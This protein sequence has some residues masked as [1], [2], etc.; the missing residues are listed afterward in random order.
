MKLPAKF[1]WLML[2]TI[3]VA[4]DCKE[5]PPNRETE[6][7][8]GSWHDQLY[9]EGTQA[10][11]KCRPG[12]RTFGTI[13]M[14]CR[15]GEWVAV[16]PSRICRKRPCGYPGD[17][18]FGSFDLVEGSEF[19]YG[20]TVVYTCEEGYRLV[21][22]IN[23]RKCEADG[24]TN[25][26]PVCEVI[27]CLPVSEPE[28]GRII[29]GGF[30]VNQEYT[31]GQVIRFEC[32][33]GFVLNAAKE[34]HCS[35][36][37]WSAEKPNCVGISCDLPHIP[38]GQPISLKTTFK[39][40]E[41]LQ[42]KCHRGYS[43]SRRADAV[44]T[45]SGWA[46][47]PECKEMT[48][49]PLRIA[50]GDYSPKSTT[51]RLEDEVTYWCKNGFY[52]ASRGTTAKC[53][54]TG[55][56]PPPRCGFK[57]CDFPE[58]KHG[59]LHHE[60]YYRPYF[61]VAI[62][63]YY[64]YS[65]ASGF[66]THSRRSWDYI[67]CGRD[68]WSPAVPCRRQCI[69]NYLENG[70]S[71]SR[72]AKYIQGDS[73]IVR[74][75]AG[76]TLQN[77]Q[78]SLT[79]TENGWSPLPK[80]IRVKT[81]SKS[82]LEIQNGF[83]SESESTYPVGKEARYKCKDGYITED[84]QTTGSIRCLQSGWSARPRC[85]KSCDMPIFE[86]ARATGD[87]TWF[88][89]N[90]NLVYVCHDGYKNG[91]GHTRGSIQCGTDGW[92]D[93]PT[94]REKECGVPNI[95]P[96]VIA[97]PKKDKYKVGDVLKF[98]C[99]RRLK[100]VGTDSVQ[101]YHFGWSPS[102]PTCKGEVR[103]CGPRPSLLN[104]EAK[105]APR[106]EYAHGEVVEYVCSPRFLMKGSNRIQCVDGEWTV[107][108]LCV[109]ENSTCDTVPEV[110]NGYAVSSAPPYRHGESVEFRCTETFAMSGRRSATCVR[111]VW[112]RPP[113]CV[114]ITEP[115]KCKLPKLILNVEPVSDK[116]TYHHN[117]NVSYT[118]KGESKQKNSICINGRWDPK[119]T[120]TEV[121][122]CPPPPQIPRARNMTTT[123]NY[124]DGDK[125]SILCE[126][127]A[128]MQGGEEIVCKNG[129]WQ[130][131]PR[132]VEK[133]PCSQPPHIEHGTVN[134]SRSSEERNGTSEPRPYAHGTK[135]SYLCEDGFR[136][137][138]ED[139]V[140]CNM[141]KWSSPPQCVGLPCGPPPL[142]P[143]GFV[144]NQ[145][146]SY[147]YGQVAEYSCSRGFEM[148]GPASIQCLGGKW[149]HPPNCT[150]ADCS[151][152]P[153]FDKAIYVGPWKSSYNSR[154]K[155]NYRCEQYYQMEGPD[156]IQCLK[157]RWIGRPTCRDTSCTNPPTVENANILH[158]R[159][160][161]PHGNTVRYECIDSLQLFGD[162]EVTCLNGT[163]TEPP[164]CKESTGKCGPP[165][166]IDNGDITTFPQPVYPPGSSV[167]YQC[168]SLYEL[169][170]N[171]KVTCTNGQWSKPPK[172][173]DA[174]VISEAEMEAHK[175]QLR[176]AYD[177]K[178]YSRTEDTVE[179][180][181][182]NGYRKISPERAF[183]VTCREGKMEY[184]TCG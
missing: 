165:P 152:P 161:Y 50:N 101:C 57:P 130:S 35:V 143:N 179:F 83:V 109:E 33:P 20:A 54:T 113:Q 163:W 145:F 137:S 51:Y 158:K 172:C 106:E 52:P 138:E 107:L 25:D 69:Y 128:L 84:G 19:V 164:Q 117:M 5:P 166:P 120:C 102:P 85:I 154:E 37:G 149:S 112:T 7:L 78:T 22:E 86:N 132:C 17:T 99:R 38:N 150:K 18:R 32:N 46:P 129:T 30:D 121:Q 136:L 66:V 62:G 14:V 77:G 108:P 8:S 147:K 75:Y 49:D 177:R 29:S 10:T 135:L 126:E 94:C 115:V 168:Q 100:I 122:R 97:E 105:N 110:A 41:R 134:I 173:L 92:S 123:V 42:Y 160:R 27:R 91:D 13:T 4:E 146:S 125:I 182:K 118:C 15:S 151:T 159:D 96:N 59:S 142:I 53:T 124:Q 184:P 111:G 45:K 156:T 170:G 183:R 88:K 127:N 103:A 24:W 148:E 87:A 116:N 16:N 73:I 39:E 74:C 61:P 133:R 93:T 131:V 153:S 178:Y 68:G 21:G 175:I 98:S 12:Y 11:Y 34:I 36:N 72:E 43:Y 55:W 95:E 171:K 6:I 2:W 31:F 89:V 81:C 65:C 26:V 70:Y 140:T 56:E 67:T 139:G 90:D 80:C 174:C 181:C 176:W 64:S 141:G 47:L 28:N 119:I 71:P 58:I 82:D 104:G 79:C 157:G 63:K 167:E 162:V 60:S 44:C 23:S 169:R 180:A 48:C 9:P 76:F 144:P 114:A 3:C 40:N 155:V 1:L